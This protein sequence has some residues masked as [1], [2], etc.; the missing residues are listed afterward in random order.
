MGIGDVLQVVG[1]TLLTIL[2]FTGVFARGS[3]YERHKRHTEGYGASVARKS[4]TIFIHCL[5]FYAVWRI[6]QTLGS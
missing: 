1:T 4:I 2:V 5:W 6:F 3:Q